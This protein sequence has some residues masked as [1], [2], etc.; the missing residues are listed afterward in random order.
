[1][2]G[3][4]LPKLLT[5]YAVLLGGLDGGIPGKASAVRTPRALTTDT[6]ELTSMQAAIRAGAANAGNE[7]ALLI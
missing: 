7:N 2:R 1:M 4:V 3:L 6:A 5:S